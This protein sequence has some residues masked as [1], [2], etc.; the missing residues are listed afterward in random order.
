[1][2]GLVV[3]AG[4]VAS[5]TPGREQRVVELEERTWLP[6]HCRG[7]STAFPALLEAYRRPVYTYLVR[8]G[9]APR[10]IATT[11]SRACS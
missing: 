5:E 3:A 10:P 1:M 4:S 7:D 11:S 2:I 8:F 9:V 6:R